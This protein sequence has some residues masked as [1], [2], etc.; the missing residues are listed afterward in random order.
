M[1]LFLLHLCQLTRML[2]PLQQWVLFRTTVRNFWLPKPE[3]ERTAVLMD[4]LAI[5]NLEMHL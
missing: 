4:L 3:R 5:R 2:H 1:E